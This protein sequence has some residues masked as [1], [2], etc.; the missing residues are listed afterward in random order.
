[1][2]LLSYRTGFYAASF[3]FAGSLVLLVAREAAFT[4]DVSPALSHTTPAA[5]V[6]VAAPTAPAPPDASTCSTELAACRA[7]T[8]AIVLR[9]IRADVEDKKAP[10]G[11]RAQPG[12][13]PEATGPDEQRRTRCDVAEQ[14]AREHWTS[15]RANILATVKDIGKPSWIADEVKKNGESLQKE[16][17]LT[18]A[19]RTRLERDEAA[20]WATHGPLFQAA[21]GRDPTD[22][23]A[24]LDIVRA[25]WRDEDAI[26]ERMLGPKGRDEHRASELRSRTAIMAVLAALAGKP[27]DD[28]LVW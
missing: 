17:G 15:Q 21:L 7:E 6:A 2:T 13:P 10:A 8:W 22:W 11:G 25:W 1:V 12:E 3:A 23:A 20:L 9:T 18:P 24:L 14:Q 26:I 5:S 4:R 27:F 19:E 28:S 16:L